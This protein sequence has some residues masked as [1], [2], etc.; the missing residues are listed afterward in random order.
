M[1]RQTLGGLTVRIAGGTDREGGGEGPAVVLLHGFGAPGDD[2][3]SLYRVLETPPGTRFVFPE[4]PLSL[5]GGLGDSRA[6]WMID[7]DAVERAIQSGE[8]RDMSADVPDGLAEA[9]ALVI[10]MLDALGPTLHV[11]EGQLVLGGFSQG[12]M[13]ALDVALH[14][15]RPLAGVVLMSGTL[16]AAE[17]WVVRM[18]DRAGLPVLQSHGERDLLLPYSAAETL[19]D[20]LGEAGLHVEWVPHRGGHEIPNPVVSALDTFLQRVLSKWT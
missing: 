17:E 11:P 19:R 8:P 4:A 14:D 7:V 20:H 1:R 3:V 12:A 5:M 16:L 13:L 6:W 9:R 10:E 15:P 2:L 18:P